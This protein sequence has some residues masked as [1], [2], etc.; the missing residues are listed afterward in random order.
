MEEVVAQLPVPYSC[1]NTLRKLMQN[2]TTI[3]IAGLQT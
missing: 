2:I 3:I 1:W